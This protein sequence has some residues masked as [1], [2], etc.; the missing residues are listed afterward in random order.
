MGTWNV[1]I[2]GNDT[3][4]DL[5]TEY[6]AAFFK[7]DVETALQK[8][9]QYVRA[10]MF[11]ESDAEEWCNYYYSLADFMW[12]KGILTDDVREKAIEMI[13]GGLGLELWAEAGEKTLNA[14]KNKL[15]EFKQKL[16]SPQPAKKRIKPNVN[17][18]KI[19]QEGD[20]VAIQLQTSGKPYTENEMRPMSD[21]EFHALDGKYVLMQSLGCI[22]SWSSSIVPEVKDYW[23]YFRLFDGIYDVVPSDIDLSTLKDAKIHCLQKMTSVFSCESSMFYFKKRKYQVIGNEMPTIDPQQHRFGASIFWG[24]NRPWINPDSQ[25]IAA[26]RKELVCGKFRGNEEELQ[27]I[28]YL[29]N[30]YGRYIYRLSRE[31]QEAIFEKEAERIFEN[32]KKSIS[33]GGELLSI[34]FGK[35]LGIVTLTGHCIDNLYIEGR[36]QRQGF[37][38]E[39]L[40]YAFSYAG[41]GAYIDVPK[42]N[43]I[44]LH[45]C[46]KIGLKEVKSPHEDYVRM[47]KKTSFMDKFYKKQ[48]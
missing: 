15:E 40:N 22:S 11:D 26:M 44:L 38:T 12:K 20:I 33:D 30:C 9:D 47:M 45:V 19:F 1:S 23:A 16:L 3:A 5:N 24:I 42:K 14:R 32:V 46:E 25:L 6:S 37:G 43:D 2:A 29:A 34:S 13:D 41:K 18:E 27:K 39:L 28:C 17:I 21:E 36:Y 4:R 8:I 10:N 7:Y 35:E 31:E 48:S